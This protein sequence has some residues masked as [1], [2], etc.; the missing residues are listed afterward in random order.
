MRVSGR[1]ILDD[2]RAVELASAEP[3]AKLASFK[4]RQSAPA[5]APAP[6]L[7]L[8]SQAS[9]TTQ[10]LAVAY[11]YALVGRVFSVES[12]RTSLPSA[13]PGRNYPGKT[14]YT[15]TATLYHCTTHLPRHFSSK[16]S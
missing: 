5:P 12:S 15:A 3:V 9:F 10:F 4:P 13:R 11:T 8:H 16:A 14:N 6:A 2:D 7:C 1:C